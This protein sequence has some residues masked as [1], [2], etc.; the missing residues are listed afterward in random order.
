[1]IIFRMFVIL[2][3]VVVFIL[4]GCGGGVGIQENV[5]WNGILDN[6]LG[7]DVFIVGFYIGLVFE[8]VDILCFKISFFDQY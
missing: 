2:V 5:D 6:I 8:I 7:L 3:I 1:M 4:F